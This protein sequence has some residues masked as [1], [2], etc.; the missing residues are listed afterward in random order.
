MDILDE[1]ILQLWQ[2]LKNN[3]VYY[4][5]VGGFANTLNG[6]VRAT[7]DVD[8]WLKNTLENRSNF[9]KTI[10]EIGIGDFKSLETTQFVAGY[11]PILLKSGYE[12]DIMTSLLGF[13]EEDFDECY[14]ISPEALIDGV[15]VKFLHI[16][17][18]IQSKKAAGREK[19]LSDIRE[20]EKIR[21]EKK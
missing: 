6:Y 14:K 9:R 5:M 13:E 20:L 4:L 1:E 17:L 16:N 15:P 3:N 10:K 18:L 8:I 19:D 11:T 21:D 7:A 12:L 2:A